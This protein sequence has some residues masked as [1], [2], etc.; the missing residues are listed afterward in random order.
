MTPNDLKILIQTSTKNILSK[1]YSLFQ[2]SLSADVSPWIREVEST[3]KRLKTG[4][5]VLVA[6]FVND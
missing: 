1:E 5:V 4:K 2:R 3:A 6:V